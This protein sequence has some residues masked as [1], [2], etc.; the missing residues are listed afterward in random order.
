MLHSS[1]DCFKVQRRRK[2]E[3][4][5]VKKEQLSKSSLGLAVAGEDP[6]HG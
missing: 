5:E 1:S 2:I 4:S 3:Q 6:H